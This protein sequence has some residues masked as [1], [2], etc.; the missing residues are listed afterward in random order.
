[1]TLHFPIDLITPSDWT[2]VA[3]IARLFLMRDA[4]SASQ[5]ERSLAHWR[6]AMN[7]IGKTLASAAL[8]TL[9]TIAFA[10]AALA[11]DTTVWVE[12]SYDQPITLGQNPTTGRDMY[13]H[14][15]V[16][17]QYAVNCGDATLSLVAWRMFSGP[18]G[19]GIL[20]WSGPH[21]TATATGDAGYAP[22]T[23][24]E[25]GALATA[26]RSTAAAR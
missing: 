23:D 2:R 14:Q 3:R 7:T 13:P 22:V 25:R 8:A 10:T 15:S 5:A 4:L 16:A 9:A 26:C 11:T 21:A 24:E 1:M 20:I 6:P 18:H 12:R 17:I 19:E